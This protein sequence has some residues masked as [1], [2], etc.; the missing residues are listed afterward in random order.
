MRALASPEQTADRAVACRPSEVAL[1]VRLNV[2]K[3]G[4]GISLGARG[5]KA[6][7]N[8]RGR[9]HVSAGKGGFRWAKL[10]W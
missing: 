9:K 7:A 8:G 1:G 10:V 2:G 5:T 6:S 3:R 4:A